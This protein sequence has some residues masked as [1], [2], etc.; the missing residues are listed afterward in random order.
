MADLEA[1]KQ[2]TRPNSIDELRPRIPTPEGKN[3]LESIRGQWPGDETDDVI[4]R[5]LEELS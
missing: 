1:L 5:A 3:W 4:D 2:R